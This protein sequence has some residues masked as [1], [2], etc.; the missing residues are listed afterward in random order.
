MIAEAKNPFP[1]LFMRLLI[2]ACFC[3]CLLVCGCSRSTYRIM[4][5]TA[6]CPCTSCNGRWAGQTAS[7]ERMKAPNAG[8]LSADSLR[9]PS[10]VPGRVLLPW[11][12]LPQK[13]T[14]AA[15][16]R[17]YPFGTEMYVEGWGLGVV[18]D[19]GG[20]IKGPDR[21]DLFFRTHAQTRE[22]GRRKVRV[23]IMPKG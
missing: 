14:I 20:A 13:G 11:R 16:T 7:G 22:W 19:V 12:A 3:C 17:Y 23:K 5:T 6:Y 1:E 21:L 9:N 18:E 2:L 10:H 8:L 15:D 4:E